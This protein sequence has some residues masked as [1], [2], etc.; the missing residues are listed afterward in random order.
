MEKAVAALPGVAESAVNFATET[1]SVTPGAGF[2]AEALLAAIEK[3]GYEAKA[4]TLV[5]EVEDMTCASCV[6]RVEKALKSV[7]SVETASVN[8]ATGEAVVKV[9][10]GVS[11]LPALTAA[12]AKAGYAV[13]LVSGGTALQPAALL[14]ARGRAALARVVLHRLRA[15][16]MRRAQQARWPMAGRHGAKRKSRAAP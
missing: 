6:S 3:A 13:R 2:S 1:L 15:W 12:V 8:L 14:R 9:L 11:A 4:E 10:G 5:L 16:G 7:P